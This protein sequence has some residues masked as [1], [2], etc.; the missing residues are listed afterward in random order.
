MRSTWRR[1]GLS[2][3]EARPTYQ[4]IIKKIVG[5]QR[6]VPDFS[7]VATNVV[8]YDASNG[9]DPLA[10]TRRNCVWAYTSR[11]QPGVQ[12]LSS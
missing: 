7:S 8:T 5:S 6:G 1:S 4:N 11:T 12:N 9:A 10:A 2:Q 3:F